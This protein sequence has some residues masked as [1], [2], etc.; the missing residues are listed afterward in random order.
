MTICMCIVI[1]RA[2]H[3]MNV[4]VS[5]EHTANAVMQ[6]CKMKSCPSEYVL[7]FRNKSQ[8]KG[9]YALS[10]VWNHRLLHRVRLKPEVVPNM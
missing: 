3:N 2:L 9:H 10:R 8:S 6:N 4:L 1:V 5:V 7:I